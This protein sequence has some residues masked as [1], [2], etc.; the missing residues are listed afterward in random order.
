M[1]SPKKARSLW[2]VVCV[3]NP[4]VIYEAIGVLEPKHCPACGGSAIARRKGA[5]PPEDNPKLLDDGFGMHA[6]RCDHPECGL[7]IV[8]PGKIACTI[9]SRDEQWEKGVFGTDPHSVRVAK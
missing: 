1:D 3:H 4:Q 9:C 7:H 6:K 2:E 8:R 5:K